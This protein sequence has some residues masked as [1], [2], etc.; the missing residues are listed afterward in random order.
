MSGRLRELI[1]RVGFVHA[2][3][4]GW[5]TKEAMGLSELAELIMRVGFAHAYRQGWP[6]KEAMA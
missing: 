3:R 6:T 5:P 1:M 2:Y 4:Q